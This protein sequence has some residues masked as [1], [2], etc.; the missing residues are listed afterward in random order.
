MQMRAHSHLVTATQIFDVLSM[1]SGMG[2]IVNNVTVHT[3]RQKKH[4]VVVK[5]EQTLKLG[6]EIK[7]IVCL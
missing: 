2:C 6:K 4:I 1:S 3:L 7:P 5:C